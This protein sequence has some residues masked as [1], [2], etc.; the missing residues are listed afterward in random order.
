MSAVQVSKS[1]DDELGRYKTWDQIIAE[2]GP[3]D[4]PNFCFIAG[5]VF[6]SNRLY[7]QAAG[8]LDRA[9]ALAPQN[10]LAR[11]WLAH[12]Y[13]ISRLPDKALELVEQIRSQPSLRDAA[14]TNR[15]D[16]LFVETAAHLAGSDVKGA[17]ATVQATVRQYPGDEGVL[18][19]ASQA[20]L[21]YGCYS[22]ALI[23]MDQQ[24][25]LSPTNLNTLVNKGYACIQAG[26]FEQ[27][28]A[29]L[30][31]VLAVQ[32]NNYSALLNRAICYLRTGKLDI[33]QRD[34]EVLQ[35]AFP[36]AYQIYFGLAEVAWQQKAT[37]AAI[38]NYQLYLANAQTNTAESK[39]V[40]DRL[41]ELKRGPP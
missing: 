2:N 30:T 18:A 13:V 29:P 31:K 25:A 16:L 14:R 17:E 40:S 3:F 41:K 32:T 34:Y 11:I 33:A 37:N 26:A 23:T 19:T 6:M 12:L 36:T 15:T 9:V 21:R 10:L 20:Y 8:Q 28:I 39:L 38:R 27:A 35:K 22:N 1:M 4:E 5:R 24:L 7:R